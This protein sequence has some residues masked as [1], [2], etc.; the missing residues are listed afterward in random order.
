MTL[1]H[2]PAVDDDDADCTII[3]TTVVTATE[4]EET[5]QVIPSS[6]LSVQN[7]AEN[8]EDDT[9]PGA[10]GS[11]QSAS[12]GPGLR[13][14]LRLGGFEEAKEE[15]EITTIP[16]MQEE[17]QKQERR[18]P[19]LTLQYLSCQSPHNVPRLPLSLPTATSRP[20]TPQKG[21]LL[22]ADDSSADGAAGDSIII[23]TT[24]TTTT[25]TT[26]TQMRL[27]PLAATPSSAA[28]SAPFVPSKQ[29]NMATTQ[30]TSSRAAKLD[31]FLHDCTLI[32][33][34]LYIGGQIV[35]SD[36]A[37]LRQH[38][39]THVVNACGAVCDN[40]FPDDFSYYRLYLQDKGS[41]DVLCILYE[42]F[43][44]VAA[45]R[46]AGGKVLIHC[47][48]G[49]S[50]STVLGIGYLMMAGE[51]SDSSGE[52][53][54][55]DYQTAYS[56]VRSKRGIS[57]PNLGFVCQLLAWSR[58]L[59]GR[60]AFSSSLYRFAPHNAN[61][62]KL[63]NKWVDTLDCSAFDARFILLL[64]SPYAFYLWVGEDVSAE[65]E[66]ASA[67]LI[68]RVVH[69]LQTYEFG[70]WNVVRIR[71]RAQAEAE[72][73]TDVTD[74][75]GLSTEERPAVERRREEVR[76]HAPADES[77]EEDMGGVEGDGASGGG[78]EG[79]TDRMRERTNRTHAFDAERPADFFYAVMG[80]RPAWHT[81]NAA[82]NDEVDAD[83][84]L[85]ALGEE[86]G[87]GVSRATSLRSA[88]SSTSSRIS[89]SVQKLQISPTLSG[90][91]RRTSATSLS[92][93][94]RSQRA[95]ASLPAV[96]PPLLPARPPRKDSRGEAAA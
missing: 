18:R 76:E 74:V 21:L 22:H 59:L 14:G 33:P 53:T 80:G 58:R 12:K 9:E 91:D 55:A 2:F 54:Y 70:V 1:S 42:V 8:G 96:G 3:T 71:R 60:C 6:A 72:E 89:V 66:A 45:A 44:F 29:S 27:L 49:V 56:R 90:V 93:S 75:Y 51:E 15:S 79:D 25:T 95:S 73:V 17:E 52:W 48:Q 84:A 20:H 11:D 36:L 65:R 34:T 19:K 46:A 31:F 57:S 26:S 67:P 81:H 64:Q 16:V 35:A 88:A 87:R 62:R 37:L 63:V 94:P 82:L 28:S 86:R 23:T 39:I 47:Q 7:S 41:E 77:D 13:L 5:R 24:T 40:Y 4:R 10:A 69:N 50:R 92:I 83:S 38:G 30:S 68:R 85:D 78:E 43:H 32:T 61:D